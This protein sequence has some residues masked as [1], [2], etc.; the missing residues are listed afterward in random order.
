MQEENFIDWTR[1]PK[2]GKI[3]IFEWRHVKLASVSS[4]ASAVCTYLSSV[5]V[6]NS[7][8][9]DIEMV[10]TN[11]ADFLGVPKSEIN[12]L[13][14][15]GGGSNDDD[16]S[17][18]PTSNFDYGSATSAKQPSEDDYAALDELLLEK[19]NESQESKLRRTVG[20]PVTSLVTQQTAQG[21]SLD[22]FFQAMCATVKTFPNA[23]MAEIKL[24]ISHI[25]GTKEI[26]IMNRVQNWI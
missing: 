17:Q 23:D 7:R 18:S 6:F 9:R 15:E 3:S 4:P 1:P 12:S 19:H 25:V 26:E 11:A 24:K 10:T 21:H 14:Y 5:I 13:E 8:A 20:V 22:I 16:R 2:R